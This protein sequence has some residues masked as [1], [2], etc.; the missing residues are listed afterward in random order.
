MH[1]INPLPA[2]HQEN[3]GRQ[4]DENLE[5][6]AAKALQNRLSLGWKSPGKTASIW[7]V[8]S[9]NAH[10]KQA[11]DISTLISDLI[12][13]VSQRLSILSD[14]QVKNDTAAYDSLH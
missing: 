10:E 12:I 4:M 1:A 3:G 7:L 2:I 11:Y 14:D 9:G 13:Q 8:S 5:L 6:S